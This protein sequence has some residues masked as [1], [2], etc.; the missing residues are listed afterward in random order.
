MGSLG[1]IHSARSRLILESETVV[2]MEADIAKNASEGAGNLSPDEKK[3]MEEL[4][5]AR[6]AQTAY[7]QEAFRWLIDFVASYFPEDQLAMEDQGRDVH[8]LHI[9]NEKSGPQGVLVYR[10]P[11][12]PDKAVVYKEM[13]EDYREEM[14]VPEVLFV[15]AETAKFEADA[16]VEN[17]A[18]CFEIP[19]EK[20][21]AKI[22]DLREELKRR[23]RLR[24]LRESL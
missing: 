3:W 16:I 24:K 9:V 13:A 17:D 1:H 19:A 7:L 4:Q 23:A 12:F 21:T 22:R 18:L 5:Q 20:L 2:K 10:L 8:F 11:K 6:E 15:D 14:K